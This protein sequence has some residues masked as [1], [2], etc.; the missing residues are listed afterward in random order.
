MTPSQPLDP[1]PRKYAPAV[2]LRR[3]LKSV[4]PA[5]G[6]APDDI[7]AWLLSEA[8]GFE[9]F[10]DLFDAFIW[11]LAAAGLGLDRANLS[12]GTLHPQLI[13]YGWNWVRAD[14][15][16][17]EVQVPAASLLTESYRRNPLFRV[18]EY[19]ETVRRRSPP[20]GETEA[21]PL[22]AELWADGFTEYLALPLR[23]GGR[24][25]N[26][27]TLATKRKDGFDTAG[28]GEIQRLMALFAL[29]VVRHA[30]TQIARNTLAAY[31]GEAAGNQ[32]LEG[33]IHRGDGRSIRAIVWVSDL[34]DYTG[35]SERLAGPEV[36]AILNAYFETLA[37][38]VMAESGEILKFVGDGLLAVFPFNDDRSAAEAAAA[39]MRAAQAAIAGEAKL[40]QDPNR[41][42]DIDGWRPLR[43]GIGLH[44]GDVFFGNVGAPDRLDFT[45]IG[46]AVNLASRVEGLTKS[47]GRPVLLTADVAHRLNL[48]DA[49]ASSLEDLG[50]HAIRG[51][52]EPVHIYAPGARRPAT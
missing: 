33:S 35:L 6:L 47:L 17:D 39:A 31:L 20:P 40:N 15:F 50:P 10:I 37:A 49:D 21:M 45:V 24:L 51:L 14:G 32:V 52:A 5:D 26:S 11:R 38:A 42:A 9:D 36:T 3:R 13:G 4:P 19:G 2:S 12:V 30:A 22:L 23:G 16:T 43:S 27:V 7:E 28:L 1:A 41:L 18:I 25:H 8:L 34:R 44:E 29:H 48:A 46:N